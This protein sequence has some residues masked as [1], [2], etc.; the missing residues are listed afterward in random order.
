MILRPVRPAALR[1]THHEFAG[2]VH[3]ILGGLAGGLEGQ[4]GGRWLHHMGP[5]VFGDALADALLNTDP[6]HF[7]GVLGGDQNRVDRDGLVVFVDDAHLGFAIGKQV[8]QSS[9]VA[10][11]GQAARQPVG[12]AD[13]QR[14]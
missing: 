3:Q 11:F 9:V 7:S 1:A 2:W 6:V 13:R 14:H 10:H 4:I 5:E 12:Q 8:T